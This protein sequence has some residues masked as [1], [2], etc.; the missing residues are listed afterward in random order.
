MGEG[1][2]PEKAPKIKMNTQKS[3]VEDRS[4]RDEMQYGGSVGGVWGLQAARL[5]FFIV[6]AGI[7]DLKGIH[8][9]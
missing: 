6:V 2:S 3:S 5:I 4:G 8:D 1:G 9:M 7:V